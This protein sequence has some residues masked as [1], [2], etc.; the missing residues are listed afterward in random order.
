MKVDM[1]PE[2]VDNRLRVMGELWELSVALMNSRV[3]PRKQEQTNAADDSTP[4]STESSDLTGKLP[5]R[6]AV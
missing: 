3:L 4:A 1:S 6:S 5:N 2:A